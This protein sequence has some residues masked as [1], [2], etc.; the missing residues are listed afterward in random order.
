MLQKLQLLNVVDQEMAAISDQKIPIYMSFLDE[1][2]KT[3]FYYLEKCHQEF[4]QIYIYL[5]YIS[6]FF[7]H[8]YHVCVCVCYRPPVRAVCLKHEVVVFQP[9][10]GTVPD[11]GY[12]ASF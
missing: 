11:L 1:T 4:S 5:Y 7:Y 8:I 9:W 10:K 2:S 12:A 3:T 6:F